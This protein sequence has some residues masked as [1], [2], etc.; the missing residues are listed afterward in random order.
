MTFEEAKVLHADGKLV[1][2]AQAYQELIEADPQHYRAMNNLGT[3]CEE[4]GD[5]SGAQKAYM[6]ARAVLP[7][8][9]II[10]Y[11]LAHVMYRQDRFQ[12]SV[13]VL[14]TVIELDPKNAAAFYNL[15]NSHLNLKAMDEA[16]S[17]FRR[18]IE[19]DPELSMAYSNLAAILLDDGDHEEALKML[20]KALSLKETGFDH[21]NLG[22][23]H[24]ARQDN[25]LAVE[26]YVKSLEVSPD[27][28]RV[29]EVLVHLLGRMDRRADALV[30][31][32]EWLEKATDNP[33]ASHLKAIYQGDVPNRASDEYVQSVFDGFAERFNQT[34]ADLEYQAP[35]LVGAALAGVVD[36]ESASLEIIDLGCGTGLCGPFLTPFA[37]RLV[38]VDL[39]SQ[40]L[41]QAKTTEHYDSLHWRELTEFL[42]EAKD[43]YDVAVSCD[44]LI[45]L[46]DLRSTVAGVHKVLRPDGWFLFTLEK[47]ESSEPF[48]ADLHGRYLH[49][50]AYV[51]SLL[52]EAG[53]SDV[54]SSEQTLRIEA[55]A[56]VAGLVVCAKKSA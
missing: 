50:A 12:A 14:N 24:E 27:S 53:F 47:S 36:A 22:R 43:Q 34:L 9:P 48:T 54:T 10:L 13:D 45:Y 31:L 38:G 25:D 26:H 20:N 4:L 41:A 55:G 35:T 18:A 7:D 32:D 29:R 8:S 11:N 21:Y 56:P 40:M 46:G 49:S 15:G 19:I 5:L 1:E 51:E 3:V 52:N 6:N 39:S 44:T 42:A 28:N 17:A 30:Q 2:A 33:V 37:R 16:R 23:I